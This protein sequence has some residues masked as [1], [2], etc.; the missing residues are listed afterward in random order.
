MIRH[1]KGQLLVRAHK[2]DIEAMIAAVKRPPRLCDPSKVS[3]TPPA[4][5]PPPPAA[6]KAKDKA[7][8]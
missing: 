3:W 7:K 4:L 1:W 8:P 2:G 5:P 6:S